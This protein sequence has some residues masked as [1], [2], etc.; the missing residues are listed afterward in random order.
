M[1]PRTKNAAATR[2]DLLASARARFLSQSYD[3]VGLRDIAGD[4]GVDVSLVGRYFGSKEDLFREVVRDGTTILQPG[5]TSRSLPCFLAQ[6]ALEH[7]PGRSRQEIERLLII[8]RSASSHKAAAVVRDAIAEDVLEPIAG[9]IGGTDAGMK[10]S[11]CLSVLMGMTILREIMS[12]EP[13]CQCDHQMIRTNLTRLL[14][15][16]LRETDGPVIAY[17]VLKD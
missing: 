5:V 3:D 13:L 14:S 2:Q 6:L 11:L 8:L 10:A 16:A 17:G 9:L 4:V 1:S 7:E 15:S 12:V